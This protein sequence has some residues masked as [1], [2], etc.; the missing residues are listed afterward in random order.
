MGAEQKAAPGTDGC[1]LGHWEPSEG[2]LRSQG[3]HPCPAPHEKAGLFFPGELI[4]ALTPNTNHHPLLTAL[5]QEAFSATSL[6]G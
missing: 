5:P 3:G 2:L 4:P 1:R 6:P